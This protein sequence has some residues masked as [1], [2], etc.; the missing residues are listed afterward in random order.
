M[1]WA[2]VEELWGLCRLHTPTPA[3][4]LARLNKAFV[5]FT[6]WETLLL[7]Q[8]LISLREQLYTVHFFKI[9][10]WFDI[11]LCISFT[12]F[13][14]HHSKEWPY[15]CGWTRA[16]CLNPL[17]SSESCFRDVTHAD[18]H[19]A[20]DTERSNAVNSPGSVFLVYFLSEEQLWAM[21]CLLNVPK[22]L[23]WRWH[24]FK[25]PGNLKTAVDVNRDFHIAILVNATQGIDSVKKKKDIQEVT[26]HC[27]EPMVCCDLQRSTSGFAAAEVHRNTTVYNPAFL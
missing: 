24:L 6:R 2:M 3:K 17:L 20:S 12:V 23:V 26:D 25:T 21:C 16:R 22:S 5:L 27:S 8:P 19:A 11:L 1:R 18:A 7:T 10:N 15:F 14:Q 9:L 13:N 4:M